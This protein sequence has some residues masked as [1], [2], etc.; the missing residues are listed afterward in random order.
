MI[1]CCVS[2]SL[3]PLLLVVLLALQI[4]VFCGNRMG[5]SAIRFISVVTGLLC[6]CTILLNGNYA[7][8]SICLRFCGLDWILVCAKITGFEYYSP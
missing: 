7:S 4:A 1:D 5:Y 8:A 6:I 3:L 2:P